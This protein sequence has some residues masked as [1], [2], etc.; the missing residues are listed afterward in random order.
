[1]AEGGAKLFWVF[2]VKN[3]DFT[4]KSY[5][6]S[7]LGGGRAPGAPPLDPPLV[8]PTKMKRKKYYTVGT[9]PKF[10]G[11]IVVTKVKSIPFTNIARYRHFIK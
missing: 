3:H 8:S 11:T 9:I 2:R 1:M 6:L 5:F 10:N 7:I 4:P